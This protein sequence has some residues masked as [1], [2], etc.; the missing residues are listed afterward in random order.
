MD[1]SIPLYLIY[2]LYDAWKIDTIKQFK[3]YYE[4]DCITMRFYMPTTNLLYDVD[5]ALEKWINNRGGNPYLK[6]ACSCDGGKSH[7]V[8]HLDIL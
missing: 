7:V 3:I 1:F 4:N 8:P 6:F 5:I 2:F